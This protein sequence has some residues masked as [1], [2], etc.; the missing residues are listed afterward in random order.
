MSMP[1]LAIY[2]TATKG[3]SPALTGMMIAVSA[4]IGVICGFIGGN[5]SDQYGRKRIMMASIFVWIFVFVGFAFAD[6]VAWFFLLNALNGV[7]RSFFEPT[8]RALLSDMTKQENKLLVFN[9]RYAAINVGVAIGPLVGL[10]LGSAKST[11]P[12]LIAAAVN[13]VY[14]IS[15]LIQF[16]KY[17]IGEIPAVQKERVSMKQS[18]QVLRKDNVFLLALIGIILGNAGYSQF[19]ST[20]SQY[21]ANAP[22]FQD[23][24]ELFSHVLVLNAITV[25]VVQ[26]PVTRVGKRYSPLVS[27]MFGTLIVSL[28]LIGF[29]MLESVPLLFACAFLFTIGEVLMF[30]MTDLFVDQIAVPHL[31][32]TYFGA[33]GFSGL[34]GVVGPWLGGMLLNTYGYDN[35]TIVFSYLA[36]LCALG[37]PLLFIVKVMVQKRNSQCNNLKMHA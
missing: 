36:L 31:K 34:G 30:S 25:L 15:L 3:V 27:I 2:L 1:F 4:L 6:H 37:F 22:V 29:G 18:A 10:Q 8:S 32:G 20:L 7:C 21:F 33:M 28:G 23:G 13:L 16:R 19:S 5:L 17:E 26:Y 12:F 14:M 9:L 11:M 24:I 35:G